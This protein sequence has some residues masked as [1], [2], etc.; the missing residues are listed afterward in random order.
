MA[1]YS[2]FL[3]APL[4]FISHL[5]L[6]H[7]CEDVILKKGCKT[8]CQIKLGSWC[9]RRVRSQ[10]AAL[11]G[12]LHLQFRRKIPAL[13]C[14]ALENLCTKQKASEFPLSWGWLFDTRPT[15]VWVF[16]MQTWHKQLR[17]MGFFYQ[18]GELSGGGADD[19]K[20]KKRS[21]VNTAVSVRTF[22]S[23]NHATRWVD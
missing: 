10:R 11:V 17:S 12:S 1:S 19:K 14:E 2:S 7:N 21:E 15:A 6:S 13:Y 23:Y 8:S 22:I 20:K 5:E 18:S 3:S 16:V 4:L 9:I